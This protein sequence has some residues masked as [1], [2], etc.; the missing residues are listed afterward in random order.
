MSTVSTKSTLQ[1]VSI[2]SIFQRLL[3]LVVLVLVVAH[4]LYSNFWYFCWFGNLTS[5]FEVLLRILKCRPCTQRRKVSAIFFVCVFHHTMTLHKC[6]CMSRSY[7]GRRNQEKR[8]QL[9]TKFISI[10]LLNISKLLFEVK[11]TC[12][13]RICFQN[14]GLPVKLLEQVT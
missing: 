5:F 7:G 14:I 12:L 6:L 4:H 3:V 2:T 1:I 13:Q 11:L 9:R 10:P 8:D